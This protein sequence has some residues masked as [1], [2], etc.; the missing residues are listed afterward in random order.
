[1]IE[2]ALAQLSPLDALHF[3][4]SL[5][6]YWQ[7][8]GQVDEGRR[9]TDE[10]IATHRDDEVA[11]SV[12]LARALLVSGELAFRQGDQA[13]AT[14]ATTEAIRLAE[15]AGDT[16]VA[17]RAEANLARIAFRDG[18]AP[19]IFEHAEAVLARAEAIGSARLK[20]A[21]VHMLGWAEYTAGN[22]EAAI[23]RFRENADLYRDAGDHV[24][25]AMELA[26][27]A[28]LAL[29]SGRA[30]DARSSLA[31]AFDTPGATDSDY[32]L[33]SFI[34]SAA[35]Y[36]AL[37][38]NRDDAAVLCA[39]SNALYES[40]GLTPDPGGDAIEAVLAELPVDE[41]SG[42]LTADVLVERARRVLG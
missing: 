28:D 25:S 27:I 8:S 11:G 17:G 30:E 21:A 2:E 6:V 15:S 22:V 1:M 12:A 18:D 29:E 14:E 41:V 7:E 26:N 33:P 34:R 19:R 39:G 32:L 35:V 37:R 3:V 38:G 4:G 13:A 9:I 23:G 10:T 5:S 31:A 36:A 24:S 20:R 42:P 40:A 16:F